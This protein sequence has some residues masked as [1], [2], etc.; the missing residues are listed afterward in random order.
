ML[1]AFDSLTAPTI[2][3]CYLR[4]WLQGFYG[5]T[6]LDTTGPRL[7]SWLLRAQPALMPLQVL[8]MEHSASDGRVIKWQGRVIFREYEEYRS[9]QRRH[10]KSYAIAWQQRLAF[11]HDII[12]SRTEFAWPPTDAAPRPDKLPPLPTTRVPAAI[13]GDAHPRMRVGKSR[14]RRNIRDMDGRRAWKEAPRPAER[15][16]RGAW[17]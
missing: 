13:H 7:L 11:T 5:E 2:A 10:G 8:D 9:D 1:R 17:R 16:R 4:I 6:C 3:G 15:A 14:L 12:S